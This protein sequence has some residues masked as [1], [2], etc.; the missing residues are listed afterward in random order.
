MD[1]DM[2]Y[3]QEAEEDEEDDLDDEDDGEPPALIPAKKA[4]DK[5]GEAAN[6]E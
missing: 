1:D 2:F 6:L 4:A 3:G 5:K